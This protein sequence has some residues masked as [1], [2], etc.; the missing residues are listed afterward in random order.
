MAEIEKKSRIS[1]LRI[2]IVSEGMKYLE[3]KL[4]KRL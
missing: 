2:T 3:L 1:N 4:V